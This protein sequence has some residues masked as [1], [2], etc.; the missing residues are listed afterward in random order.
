MV[1]EKESKTTDG[2]NES[3]TI[4]PGARRNVSLFWTTLLAIGAALFTGVDGLSGANEDEARL[5]AEDAD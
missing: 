3:E 5:G 2:S 4:G 1:M